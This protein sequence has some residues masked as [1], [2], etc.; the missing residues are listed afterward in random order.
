[1]RFI[2]AAAEGQRDANQGLGSWDDFELQPSAIRLEPSRQ[3][4]SERLKS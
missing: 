1:M 3:L 2:G 4:K